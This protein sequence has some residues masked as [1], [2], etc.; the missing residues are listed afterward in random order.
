M[1]LFDFSIAKNELLPRILM[2]A[3]AVDKRQALAILS[4]FLFR[5]QN[6]QLT[7]TATDLEIEMSAQINCLS[8]SSEGEITIP[9]K[10]IIDIL[11]SLDEQSTPH[12]ICKETTLVVKSGRSQ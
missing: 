6:N 9:A 11:R 5:I 2:L 12:F 4:N 3:G 7:I 1:T 8:S 10:K